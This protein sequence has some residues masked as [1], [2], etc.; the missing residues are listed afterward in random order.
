MDPEAT[1]NEA[2]AALVAGDVET[3]RERLEAFR[4]WADMFGFTDDVMLEREKA[5]RAV[6]AL[7]GTTSHGYHGHTFA[8]AKLDGG[9]FSVVCTDPVFD[10]AG[11]DHTP[12]PSAEIVGSWFGC[13]VVFSDAGDATQPEAIYRAKA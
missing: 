9:R 5:I 1:L 12:W 10:D 11:V 13:D 2:Q 8:C 6:L 4:E 7:H 3:C